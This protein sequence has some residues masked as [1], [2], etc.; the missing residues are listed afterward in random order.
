MRLGLLPFRVSCG[1]LRPSLLLLLLMC[2]NLLL[3]V[4]VLCI[5]FFFKKNDCLPMLF[6]A[7]GAFAF[8]L[9]KTT[10]S[11]CYFG[12]MVYSLFY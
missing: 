2:C 3:L 12:Q 9:K 7:D 10:A 1:L 11:Q 8:F 6:R 4:D 5:R